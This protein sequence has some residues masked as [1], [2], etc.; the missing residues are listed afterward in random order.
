[1]PDWTIV[2]TR[3]TF[4]ITDAGETIKVRVVLWRSGKDGPFTLELPD[5][6]F[7]ADRV[8]RELDRLSAE[9]VALRP[10]ATP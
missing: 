9:L 10:P 4:R 3:E 6:E 7:S 2:Q 8:R 5:S 1:M